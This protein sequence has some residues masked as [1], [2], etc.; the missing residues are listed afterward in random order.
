VRFLNVEPLDKETNSIVHDAIALP[1]GRVAAVLSLGPGPNDVLALVL[2]D[3][4]GRRLA[5]HR[6]ALFTLMFPAGSWTR[7]HA[8]LDDRKLQSLSVLGTGSE[9]RAFVQRFGVMGNVPVASP[10]RFLGAGNLK[11]GVMTPAD[12]ALVGLYDPKT[13]A[14][15]KLRWYDS[16]GEETASHD[17]GEA[18]ECDIA[19]RRDGSSVVWLAP[20]RLLAFDAAGKPLWRAELPADAI[21]VG[22]MAEGDIAAIHPATNGVDVV[23]YLV[24]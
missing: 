15:L 7:I 4:A 6:M 16:G 14:A 3:G 12:G 13:E 10:T 24:R 20:R 9:G 19:L 8:R 23:R 11:C 2:F 5:D 22:W 1:D 21:A 17:A 18:R